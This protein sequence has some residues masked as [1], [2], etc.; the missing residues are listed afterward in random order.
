MKGPRC[1]NVWGFSLHANVCIPAR[2]RHE[3]ENLCRYAA[4]SAVATEGLA[5][6]IAADPGRTI[7][8]V[9][10]SSNTQPIEIMKVF[11]IDGYKIEQNK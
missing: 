4:R 10:Q 3:L 9:A 7:K 8:S 1:P 5:A 2:A 6:G 11:L